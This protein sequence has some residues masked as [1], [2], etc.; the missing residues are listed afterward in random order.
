MKSKISTD[1]KPENQEDQVM[2]L[3]TRNF[4]SKGWQEEKM[5]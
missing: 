1:G 2:S 4:Q 5:M 3:Y